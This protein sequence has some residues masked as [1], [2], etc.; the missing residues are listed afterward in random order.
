MDSLSWI[1]AIAVIYFIFFRKKNNSSNNRI[2]SKTPTFTI[3]TTEIVPILVKKSDVSWTLYIKKRGEYS[4]NYCTT[5]TTGDHAGN[6]S[7]G[8]IN[9]RYYV[10]WN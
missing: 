6:S 7:Y 8:G 5:I 1:I 4:K 2:F 9:F 3:D 10:D